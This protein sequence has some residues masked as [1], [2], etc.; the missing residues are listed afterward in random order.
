V[1]QRRLLKGVP[2]LIGLAITSWLPAYLCHDSWLLA[3]WTDGDS[4][5]G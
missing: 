3:M 1:L 5:V 2:V 4:F